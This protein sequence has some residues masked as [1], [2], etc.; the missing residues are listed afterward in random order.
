ML[1]APHG[2]LNAGAL[3]PMTPVMTHRAITSDQRGFALIE[4]IVAAV[5]LA[6]VALALLAGLEGA[7]GSAGREKARATASTVAEQDQERMRAM[8]ATELS[9]YRKQRTVDVGGVPYQVSSRADWVRDGS[10]ASENCTSEPSQA[11][12]LKITSTVTSEV[13]GSRTRPATLSSLVAPP[14]GAFGRDRGT[15]AV[16][17]IDRDG[18]GVRGMPV[19]IRGPEA[20]DDATNSVGCAVFGYLPVGSYDVKVAQAGYIDPSRVTAVTEPGTVTSGKV[21]LTTIKYDRAAR[22]RVSFDTRPWDAAATP[23]GPGPS[24]ESQADALRMETLEAPAPLSFTAQAP[25]AT[26]DTGF[27]LFPFKDGYAAFSGS[28]TDSNPLKQGVDASVLLD[29]GEEKA[30]TIRQPALNVTVKRLVGGSWQ[31][32]SGARVVTTLVSTTGCADTHVL[33]TAADG[34]VTRRA[35]PAPLDPGLP[36]GEYDVCASSG[37][38]YGTLTKIANFT[39]DGTAPQELKLTATGTC[40]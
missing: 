11:D 2:A 7:L 13:I 33:T 20:H 23:P 37:G 17:I 21:S 32:K 27:S 8:P 6:T 38:R 15:L 3:E 26:T 39:P 29:P 24:T 12:Y 14:I 28:C 4:V 30:V 36:F 34:R 19:S 25:P 40:P 22:L 9:N 5:V 35:A 31:G 18:V 16:K 10:A 1:V